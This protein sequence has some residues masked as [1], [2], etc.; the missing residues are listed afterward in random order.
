MESAQLPN[1]FMAGSQEQVI[2]VG[3][4]DWRIDLIQQLLGSHSLDGRLRTH[5]H[6]NRS[7]DRPVVRV[8]ET[9]SCPRDRAFRLNFKI[10]QLPAYLGRLRRYGVRGSPMGALR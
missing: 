5:G 4:E 8:E 7:R 9:G 10:R 3:K 6:E 1:G 2:G